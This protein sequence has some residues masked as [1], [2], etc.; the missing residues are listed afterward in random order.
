MISANFLV[1]GKSGIGKSSLINYLF[2]HPVADVG[3]GDR[4]TKGADSGSV[5]IHKYPA[6]RFGDIDIVVNDSWGLEADK[7]DKWIS[8]IRKEM[9]ERE[10]ISGVKGW[11]HAVVYCISVERA[12]I[13]PEFEFNKV[14]RPLADAGYKIVFALTKADIQ[15]DNQDTISKF[16][17]IINEK[18]PDHA[19]IV[20][21]SSGAK[22]RKGVSEPFGREALI[23]HMLYAMRINAAHKIAARLRVFAEEEAGKWR[24]DVL[25][26]YDEN[27][28]LFSRQ[29]TLMEKTSEFSGE[30]YAVLMDRIHNWLRGVIEYTCDVQTGF[31]VQGL[32]QQVYD[33]LLGDDPLI[34]NVRSG[35]NFSSTKDWLVY[36]TISLIPIVNI[37]WFFTKESIYRDDLDKL[38]ADKCEETVS[39][40]ARLGEEVKGLMRL[41][42]PQLGH[43]V[44]HL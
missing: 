6:F 17:S 30:S 23:L 13:E 41:D 32:G 42:D 39:A 36:L 44:I 19:G 4:V 35:V 3:T 11:F 15:R 38:L 1:V 34:R 7:A 22:K 25:S 33:A 26:F 37:A 2:Q 8:A 29:K 20:P 31:G 5:S 24:R 27:G 18:F 10:A 40:F 43:N 28:G 9:D 12:R 14:L 16:T 21:V